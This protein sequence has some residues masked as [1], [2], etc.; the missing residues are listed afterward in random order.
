MRAAGRE[1]ASRQASGGGREA[2]R[3]GVGRG[4]EAPLRRSGSTAR[5]RRPV[6]WRLRGVQRALLGRPAEHRP[7]PGARLSVSEIGYLGDSM[8]SFLDLNHEEEEF[9]IMCYI[10]DIYIM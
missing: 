8:F 6:C 3:A 10:F 1:A 2:T 7:M 5:A 9:S 4:R